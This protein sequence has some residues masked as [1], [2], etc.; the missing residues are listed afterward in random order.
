MGLVRVP[1]GLWYPL[2]RPPYYGT[3][4]TGPATALTMNTTGQQV[5]MIGQICWQDGGTH[6]VD[7]T[8]SSAISF[9]LGSSTFAASTM[10]IGIQDVATGSGPLAQPD[11]TFDVKVTLT[12]SGL[13]TSAWNN[14]ALTS[15]GSGTKTMAHGDP[16]AVDWNLT[17]RGGA[18]QIALQAIPGGGRSFP[19][20]NIFTSGA[21]QTSS[22]SNGI[23]N[24]IITAS[25][26]T[27]GKLFATFPTSSEAS[28]TFK[29]GDAADERG[30][31]VQV[32]WDD[33]L[34]GYWLL[35]GG[36]DAASDGTITL[37]A[38]PTGTPAAVSG[39]TVSFLAEQL[40]Q[41]SASPS[42]QHFLLP[43]PVSLSKNT[44]YC[45]ALKA[46]GASN[47]IL[48]ANTLGAAG[49]RALCDGGSTLFKAT[50]S[51]GG[52][53][54]FTTSSTVI[55]TMGLILG[56]FNDSGGSAHSGII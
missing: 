31:I 50:R 56:S 35:M 15:G 14:I 34:V 55:Y 10:D 23:P 36:V 22:I 13:T 7:T 32:P 25:D 16:I 2:N 1:N 53:G 48:D 9:R 40:G 24:V 39:T 27:L 11:G 41:L 19:L 45:M 51:A 49:Y 30:M 18:D 6:T 3:T 44:D 29:S 37:Y 43:T 20:T 12:N 42:Y 46:T 28:E 47:V 54:A 17:S 4:F 38:S 26:G 5:A 21:W 33:K 8:G 52:G